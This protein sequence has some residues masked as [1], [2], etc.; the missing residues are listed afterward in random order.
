MGRLLPTNES[1]ELMH[2]VGTILEIRQYGTVERARV[3]VV[4]PVYKAG[5]P[6]GYVGEFLPPHRFAGK[7]IALNYRDVARVICGY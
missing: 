3:R 7:H 4:E 1:R 6:W 2:M 5:D